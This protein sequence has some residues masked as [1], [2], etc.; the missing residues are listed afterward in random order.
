MLFK[1]KINITKGEAIRYALLPQIMPRI[2][3]FFVAGFGNLSYFMA[4]VFQAVNILPSHHPYLQRHNSGNFSIRNV[5]TEAAN[6]IDF[7]Y[8][9]ID[10]VIV[11]FSL[12]AGI[13]LLALQFFI[14]IASMAVQPATAAEQPANYGEFFEF[15]GREEDLALRLLDRVFGVPNLF[16]SK[17]A[18]QTAFHEALHGLFQFY[19]IGL[20][21]VAA[22]ILIYFIFVVVAETAQTGTP[23]GKRFNHAWAPIRLVVA[24]GLLIPISYGFNAAQWITLYAAKFGSGFATAGWVKFNETLNDN[25]LDPENL[26]S[27]TK[28]PDLKNMAAFSM[29]SHGCRKAYSIRNPNLYINSYIIHKDSYLDLAGASYKDAINFSKGGNIYIRVGEYSAKHTDFQASVFPYC[30]DIVLQNTEPDKSDTPEGQSQQNSLTSTQMMNEQYYIL[31]QKMLTEEFAGIKEA[32]EKHVE[33]SLSNTK[34]PDFNSSLRNEATNE[35]IEFMK[36]KLEEAVKKAEDEIK[37][38]DRYKTHGWASAG[39]WYNQIADVNGRMTSATLNIPQVKA[40]PSSMERVCKKVKQQ[41]DKVDATECY[42]PGMSKGKQVELSSEVEKDTAKALGGIFAF[43]YKDKDS[44]TDNA[45]IDVINLI[46]G[47]QGVFDM[48]ENSDDHPLAQLSAAG[49]GLIEASIRNIGFS[50][51]F[52]TAGIFAGYFGPALSAVS[53]F[54]SAAVT[55][56]ILIGFILFYLIPFMPFLYFLFAVGGWVK[57][58]FEAMVGVPLWALAHLRIDGQGLPGDGAINGYF[59]IFEIF[60]RPILIVFG[61]LASILIFGASVKVLNE[62]FSLVVSNLS[63]FDVEGASSCGAG[64][65]NGNGGTTT[66]SSTPPTGSMEYF[67]GPIDEFF[68]TIVYAIIV[69]M[70]G[71]SSFKLIDMIPN[72]ILRWMG[73]GVPTF[74][75]DRGEPAEGLISKMAVAGGMMSQQLDVVS[76]FKSGTTSTVQGVKEAI[77]PV[78]PQGK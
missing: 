28:I 68:F 65:P 16:G 61:L 4:L 41:N 76:K 64:N 15:S 11:F 48:C 21:I 24:I 55:S 36:A 62:I 27:Q 74:N 19:S 20:L 12:I 67:R 1:D 46:L 44:T 53:G 5:L 42:Y 30:G 37:K 22:I 7:R 63:G 73:A 59:L 57:G 18:G 39:M 10:K 78:K 35:A 60:L 51:G 69:Y 3:A 2:H 66:T 14:L 33:N 43:W 75:D 29:I 54:F 17:D 23:F 6:H 70:I 40:F 13:I 26:V 77:T 71:T 56:G 25:T 8:K 47:T 9:N 72:Q 49:K 50:L 38:D 58:I 32:A 52:G 34:H 31:L 45:F